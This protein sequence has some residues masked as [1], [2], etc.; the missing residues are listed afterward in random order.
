ME[1]I[2]FKCFKWTTLY[3]PL[4]FLIS[5]YTEK[6]K[7]SIIYIHNCTAELLLNVDIINYNIN[8]LLLLLK[9]FDINA[10]Q[11]DLVIKKNIY[12]FEKLY[13][14]K[15]ILANYIEIYKVHNKINNFIS[16]KFHIEILNK[17]IDNVL[18]YITKNNLQFCG[19]VKFNNYNVKEQNNITIYNI[20]C[21]NLFNVNDTELS[22]LN[23]ITINYVELFFDIECEDLAKDENE[24]DDDE[25]KININD[26]SIDDILQISVVINNNNEITIF[27]LSIFDCDE[28]LLRDDALEINNVNYI[29]CNNQKKLLKTFF[30]II[31]HYNVDIIAGYNI[32]TFDWNRILKSINKH[33][34]DFISYIINDFG[35]C[36]INSNVK[37]KI[38]DVMSRKKNYSS[39]DEKLNYIEF[40]GVFTLDLYKYMKLFY[41]NESQYTLKHIAKNKLK[42]YNKLDVDYKFIKVVSKLKRDINKGY[43]NINLYIKEHLKYSYVPEVND[44]LQQI[45]KCKTKSELNDLF[46]KAFSEIGKY[47]IVDSLICYHLNKTLNCSIQCI[48][49]S[50]I[51]NVDL[52]NIINKGLSFRINSFIFKESY[53]NDI[54]I[55]NAPYN[56][57]SKNKDNYEGAKVLDPKT[58]YYNGILALDFQSLYPSII[59]EY[60]LCYSTF[61]LEKNENTIT[62]IVKAEKYDREYY[63]YNKEYRKGVIPEIMT[64]LKNDRINVKKLMKQYSDD[65]IQ[66]I[67][68]DK[69]QLA[70]KII[71]NS[72]YGI[73]G[74]KYIHMLRFIPIADT[75]TFLGRELFDSLQQKLTNRNFEVIYGDTD[76]NLVKAPTSIIPYINHNTKNN[77]Q[78]LIDNNNIFINIDYIHILI[79]DVNLAIDILNN[80]YKLTKLC[81][82]KDLKIFKCKHTIPCV[83][84]DEC[85]NLFL[86]NLNIVPKD[87]CILNLQITLGNRLDEIGINLANEISQDFIKTHNKKL[88]L[89]YEASYEH[90]YISSK[91]KYSCKLYN[92]KITEKGVP[93][94]VRKNPIVIKESYRNAINSLFEYGDS[95]QLINILIENIIN[96]ITPKPLNNY[97]INMNVKNFRDYVE[98]I[99]DNTYKDSKGEYFTTNKRQ[100]SRFVLKSGQ[101]IAVITAYKIFKRDGMF[102]ENNRLDFIYYNKNIIEFTIYTN[103]I[104]KND[105]IHMYIKE[106]YQSFDKTDLTKLTNKKIKIINE[107]N[108]RSLSMIIKLSVDI[109]SIITKKIIE[110]NLLTL[111]I[112]DEIVNYNE[113]KLF[114]KIAFKKYHT[115]N[116]YNMYNKDVI[117]KNL[118]SIDYEYIYNNKEFKINYMIYIGALLD[119]Y[120]IMFDNL[121][122]NDINKKHK[123]SYYYNVID[124]LNID[125]DMDK[126]ISLKINDSKNFSIALKKNIIN[127]YTLLNINQK[128]W[129]YKNNDDVYEF[130]LNDIYLHKCFNIVHTEIKTYIIID[131]LYKIYKNTN[132]FKNYDNF[133]VLILDYKILYTK[134][135]FN[136]I[137]NYIYIADKFCIPYNI[138]EYIDFYKNNELYNKNKIKYIDKYNIKFLNLSYSKKFGKTVRYEININF[139]EFIDSINKIIKIK[140]ETIKNVS[141][142][143]NIDYMSMFYLIN[144]I[145]ILDK[146]IKKFKTNEKKIKFETYD[147][148]IKLF[149]NMVKFKYLCNNELL[150]KNLC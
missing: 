126:L 29:H 114:A 120:N 60:N 66:Y 146:I 32:N 72:I 150:S 15:I 113:Y 110:N 116:V 3:N 30:N 84:E 93:T 115:Y 145:N 107:M 141:T 24:E 73:T 127:Q 69:Q 18:M 47:C 7:K 132:I 140:Y 124:L 14:Y 55:H 4:Q 67:I 63:F 26:Y 58:G 90:Y 100:D 49:M 56:Y 22:K 35:I 98:K 129:K 51:I 61:S 64:K 142:R 112:N 108:E 143:Q 77:I 75:V 111:M 11:Y 74:M 86:K 80:K 39:F 9:Y 68:L 20:N 33:Y 137:N 54:I 82:T 34:S 1:F 48:E 139:F 105:C 8:D 25:E 109:N 59:E 121:K 28:K 130:K 94:V 99:S 106:Y 46:K 12:G 88:V 44:F 83:N 27:L 43:K 70:I 57:E 16:E 134:N 21:D 92:N 104:I 95:S 36:K 101:S 79:T 31:E 85:I 125:I 138:V 52:D 136:N 117:N 81:F 91:K 19:W 71:A 148:N 41:Q 62:Y 102:P 97:I 17:N 119:I 149:R 123:Y 147:N 37:N 10:L 122:I 40:V 53:N 87:I 118:Y 13:C 23:E 38:V 50:N 128:S 6:K 135:I 2:Y 5:G 96:I 65:S 144:S 133:N 45:K 89:V 131:K 76:S 42:N 78:H 103:I